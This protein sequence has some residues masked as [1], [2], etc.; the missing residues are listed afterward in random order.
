[1]TSS[2]KPEVRNIV[3]RR[4]RWTE[5]LSVGCEAASRGISALGDILVLNVDGIIITL[6]LLLGLYLC[7]LNASIGYITHGERPKEEEPII[8][9]TQLLSLQF[10]LR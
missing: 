4:Q 3:Q 10:G 1:M 8:V 6:K 2:T 7:G 9:P 5:P